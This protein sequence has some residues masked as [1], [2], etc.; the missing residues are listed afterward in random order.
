MPPPYE[1]G[2]VMTMNRAAQV[3]NIAMTRAAVAL[4]DP[5]SQEANVG[6][7]RIN[8]YRAAIIIWT[9]EEWEK[10]SERPLDAQFYPSGV[11]CAL[12]ME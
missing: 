7:W 9:V 1:S 8:G 11:W 3:Q 12:R 5:P 2:S 10:L 4:Y 6:R